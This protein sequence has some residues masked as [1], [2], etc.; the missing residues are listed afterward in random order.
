M[1]A[2]DVHEVIDRILAIDSFQT[3]D[4]PPLSLT[5][6][7]LQGFVDALPWQELRNMTLVADFPR[8]V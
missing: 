8:S 5:R 1:R 2:G 6:K 4:Y 7:T 3:I